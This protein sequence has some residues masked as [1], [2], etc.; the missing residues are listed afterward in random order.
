MKHIKYA[1]NRQ[2]EYPKKK[3]P[4]WGAWKYSIPWQHDC[5]MAYLKHKAQANYRKEQYALTE[6]EWMSLWN[7][8]MWNLRGRGKGN[9]RLTRINAQLPWCLSNVEF[10][11]RKRNV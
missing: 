5:H 1:Y 2:P 11:V 9:V 6:Q 4:K 3:G 7:E 10:V 8:E